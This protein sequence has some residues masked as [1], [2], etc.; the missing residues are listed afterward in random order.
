MFT[1]EQ[2]GTFKYTL[3]HVLA[4]N[5]VAMS[6]GVWRWKY[7]FHDAEKPWLMLLARIFYKD[8]YS[9]VQ[10]WHRTHNAHHLEYYKE[11]TT[12]TKRRNINALEMIIDWECSRFT[13][14]ASPLNAY[15]Q[16]KKVE[17]SLPEI[18]R[19]DLEHTLRLHGLWEGGPSCIN[20]PVGFADINQN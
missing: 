9:K 3:A 8:P 11:A 7:I 18:V 6:L 2:R 17:H 4:F 5:V 14:L 15:A 19:V 16:F 1:K 13:K 20:N 10:H 12:K